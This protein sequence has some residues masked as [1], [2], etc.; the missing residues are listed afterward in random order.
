[1]SPGRSGPQLDEWEAA[2]ADIPKLAVAS[3]GGALRRS[4]TALPPFPLALLD[5]MDGAAA[6]RTY[7]T[8]SFLAHVSS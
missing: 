8:I 6:W 7:M 2:M 4:L 3:G 1:M 5:R